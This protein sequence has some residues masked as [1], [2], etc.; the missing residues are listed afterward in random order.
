[1]ID[2][3]ELEL[4][5]RD[6]GATAAPLTTLS[7]IALALSRVVGSRRRIAA[8]TVT[9]AGDALVLSPDRSPSCFLAES[10][11]FAAISTHARP[12]RAA[13]SFGA[14]FLR[15]LEVGTRAFDVTDRELGFAAHGKRRRI[16]FEIGE[17][18]AAR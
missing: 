5:A 7:S 17:T 1:M 13:S 14:T 11:S 18:L 9:T 15:R 12:T 2:A 4:G 10:M 6:I 8:L 3:R 16:F